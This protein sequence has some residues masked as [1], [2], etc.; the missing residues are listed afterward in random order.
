[1]SDKLIF[2]VWEIF[3]FVFLSLLCANRLSLNTTKSEVVCR[4]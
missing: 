1:M 4:I 2:F 3:S